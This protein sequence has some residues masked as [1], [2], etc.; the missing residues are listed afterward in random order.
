MGKRSIKENK[1]IYQQLREEAGLTREEA[2]DA[3]GFIS[4][5]RIEK[6]ESGKSP[7][8][9]EEVL[10]MARAYRKPALCNYYCSHECPIG[11]E[12]IPEVKVKDLAQI[13]LQTL[14]TMN[15]LDKAKNRFIEI[16]ADGQISED[17]FTDFVRIENGIKEIGLEADSLTLWMENMI[18]SGKID[19]EKL[20]KARKTL[21]EDSAE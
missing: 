12:Y 10:A 9:P 7:V 14:S 16:T 19:R 1:N 13:V 18:A 21:A 20:E 11:Q 2:A 15:S 5:S 8:H 4:E 3:L 6:F 17:E